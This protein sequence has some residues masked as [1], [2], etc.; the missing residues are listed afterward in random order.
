MTLEQ[1]HNAT[2]AL[3]T[4][5]FFSSFFRKMAKTIFSIAHSIDV[6]DKVK[7]ALPNRYMN[8]ITAS[9]LLPYLN[10]EEKNFTHFTIVR[11]PA[12]RLLSVFTHLGLQN[13]MHFIDFVEIANKEIVSWH[14]GENQDMNVFLLPQYCFIY[15]DHGNCLVDTVIKLEQLSV[16]WS[17]FVNKHQLNLSKTVPH[18]NKSSKLD[19]DERIR[20]FINNDMY[21]TDTE[22]FDY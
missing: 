20:S 4:N 8:H 14:N 7:F 5:Y 18:C 22:L 1:K 6:T 19:I 17:N 3:F 12:K 16:S 13:S 10:N 9:D 2:R 21:R 15:D 11:E